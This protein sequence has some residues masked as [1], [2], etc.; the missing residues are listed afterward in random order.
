MEFY[1]NLVIGD[2]F[3]DLISFDMLVPIEYLKEDLDY[4]LAIVAKHGR[5]ILLQNN[6]P[7]YI[8][9]KSLETENVELN[10]K[11]ISSKYKLHEA[12]Q[13]VLMEK[14][15]KQMHAVEL[16]NEIYER[17]LYRKKNGD[18]AQANQIRARTEN[19]SDLFSVLAGNII[20]LR[21]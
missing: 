10:N 21:N 4:V 14:V 1:G 11:I 18:K 20:K 8:I 2:D 9:E 6:R 13:I 3:M 19:Y 16:A 15:N 17:G 5:A 12:M 7:S